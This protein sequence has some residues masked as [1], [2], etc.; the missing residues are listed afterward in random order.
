MVTEQPRLRNPVSAA[1][2]PL[3]LALNSVD[4]QPGL[5]AAD[6]HQPRMVVQATRE[7]FGALAAAGNTEIPR[8]LHWLYVRLP[9]RFAMYYWRRVLS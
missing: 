2:V 9:K 3:T 5:L 6:Q 4:V 8:N 7:V 1:R